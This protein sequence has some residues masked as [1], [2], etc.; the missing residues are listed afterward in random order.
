MVLLKTVIKKETE[1]EKKRPRLIWPLS[2]LGVVL[3]CLALTK[4]EMK[5]ATLSFAIGAL[6]GFILDYVGVAK[7]KLWTYTNQKFL[8]KSFFG[9]II[10]AWGIFDM[11]I[12]LIWNWLLISE[13]AAFSCI[14]LGLFTSHEIPNLK[15]KEWKYSV[16]MWLVIPGWLP[17]IMG[18]RLVFI[19][20]S[21]LV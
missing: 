3:F 11:T 18:F 21:Q 10:P 4:G 17:L 12:N 1:I 6:G 14:T 5:E 9:I 15:T 8:S 2:V 13:I 16:P 7:L 20:F 19:L